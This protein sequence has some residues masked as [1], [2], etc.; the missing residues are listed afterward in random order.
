MLRWA[1]LW[2][3]VPR[4]GKYASAAARWD[5]DFRHRKAFR[6]LLSDDTEKDV[7][8]A[9]VQQLGTQE[10]YLAPNLN[11]ANDLVRQAVRVLRA[12]D[13]P[14]LQG[15]GRDSGYLSYAS[16]SANSTSDLLIQHFADTLPPIV[17]VEQ[18]ANTL[19]E[20]DALA[21]I[22]QGPPRVRLVALGPT[23]APMVGVGDA[24]W[25]NSE[26][27]AGRLIVQ[28]V[29]ERN[30]GFVGLWLAFL[31][32]APGHVTGITGQLRNLEATPTRL[33]PVHRQYLRRVLS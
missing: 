6:L 5:E 14:V 1:T 2:L 25:I 27:S 15:V 29:C 32:H 10:I 33:G 30:E 26:S 24:I 4:D 8:I 11:N 16:L 28:D 9:D 31:R 13:L 22:Y 21:D 19:I 17:R 23:G 18:V 12:R 3:A 7:S 20:R